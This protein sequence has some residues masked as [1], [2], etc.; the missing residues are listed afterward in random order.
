MLVT[1]VIAICTFVFTSTICY[2]AG[3]LRGVKKM[4]IKERA[5]AELPLSAPEN[6]PTDPLYEKIEL[7]DITVAVDL[8][9]NLAYETI[10]HT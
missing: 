2:T 7:E 5:T 9:N 8:S 1:V 6:P 4:Q 3:Y 10:K